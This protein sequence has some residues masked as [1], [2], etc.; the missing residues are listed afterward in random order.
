[1]PPAAYCI[2]LQS[3]A[4][5]SVIQFFASNNHCWNSCN[6]PHRST[7]TAL[8]PNLQTPDSRFQTQQNFK[9]YQLCVCFF[10]AMGHAC[11]WCRQGVKCRFI[12]AERTSGIRPGCW[13]IM[14]IN[15]TQ[16]HWTLLSRKQGKKRAWRVVSCFVPLFFARILINLISSH[17]SSSSGCFVL[18]LCPAAFSDSW[19]SCF[20]LKANSRLR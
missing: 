17:S 11:H 10:L 3:L 19:S 2:G 4:I 5:I 7:S 8:Q 1:M 14:S 13:Q 15:I 9:H 12:E 6:E 20:F 16:F 18:L